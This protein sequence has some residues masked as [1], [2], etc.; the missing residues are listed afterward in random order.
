M[1]VETAMGEEKGSPRISQLSAEIELQKQGPTLS[2]SQVLS[3]G[4]YHERN[5]N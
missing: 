2:D 3:S 1:E 5:I 4:C